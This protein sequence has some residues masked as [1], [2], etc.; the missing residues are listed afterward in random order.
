MSLAKFRYVNLVTLWSAMSSN[1][2]RIT[3]ALMAVLEAPTAYALA[4]RTGWAQNTIRNWFKGGSF[5]DE[6]KC[7]E[8]AA[9][10]RAA[11]AVILCVVAAD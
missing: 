5:P 11:P 9:A 2:A 10:L 4:K 8:I 6:A 3:R 1:T 7:L